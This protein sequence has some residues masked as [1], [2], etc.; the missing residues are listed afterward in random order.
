MLTRKQHKLLLFIDSHLKQTGFSPSFDEMKEAMGLRSK[1]GIHRL[2][3]GLEERGF[4]RRHHHRARALEVIQ[5]PEMTDPSENLPSNVIRGDFSRSS[6][7]PHKIPLYGRIAAGLPIEALSDTTAFLD[8][9]AELTGTGEY[10]ALEVAG[11]S[12]IEAGI[13]DGDYVIIKRTDTVENGQIVVALIDDNDVTLKRLRRKGKAIAL[14]AANPNY[15]TRIVP[16][17]RLKIQGRLAALIRR[18]H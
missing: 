15:E 17:E 12:M 11:D 8:I 9:P 3:S 1:S 5:L 18:Y 10:Y 6:A 4:L 16:A 14:E 2:I 7:P 13:M